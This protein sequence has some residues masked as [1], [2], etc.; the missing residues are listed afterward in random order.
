M[1]PFQYIYSKTPRNKEKEGKGVK[2]RFNLVYFI[3][4]NENMVFPLCF[5]IKN[6]LV[7][8]C[9]KLPA[10]GEVGEG[11]KIYGPKNSPCVSLP[12]PI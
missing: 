10:G 9:G 5:Y 11:G 4:F 6:G 8:I 1:V 3:D 2:M 7:F 12:A